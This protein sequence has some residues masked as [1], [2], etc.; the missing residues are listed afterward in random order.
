MLCSRNASV[1]KRPPRLSV[2]CTI[3]EYA[4]HDLAKTAPVV[5]LA[6]PKLG[7]GGSSMVPWSRSPPADRRPLFARVRDNFLGANK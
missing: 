7:E 3:Y 5:S 6:A 4:I 1:T 2:L